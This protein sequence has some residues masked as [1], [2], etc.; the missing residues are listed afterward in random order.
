MFFLCCLRGF[1]WRKL[2][3]YTRYILHKSLFYNIYRTLL[4]SKDNNDLYLSGMLSIF[5]IV[6]NHDCLA[7]KHIAPF[8]H[9]FNEKLKLFQLFGGA[10]WR[11]PGDEGKKPCDEWL[12]HFLSI[13]NNEWRRKKT[14][15]H[16]FK[17]EFEPPEQ[18]HGAQSDGSGYWGLLIAWAWR[19]VDPANRP[20]MRSWDWGASGQP[21]S[22]DLGPS[23]KVVMRINLYWQAS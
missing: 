15:R 21:V 23:I 2:K 14:E 12:W 19:K 20:M 1:V 7:E 22:H 10:V 4:N 6:I 17:S 13:K 3:E 18:Y 16:T 9:D 5:A 11:K 8:I